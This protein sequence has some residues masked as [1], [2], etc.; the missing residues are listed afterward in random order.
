M[1]ALGGRASLALNSNHIKHLE[2]RGFT[3]NTE[4]G[5]SYYLGE[6]G[7]RNEFEIGRL[8]AVWLM[9]FDWYYF[10]NSETSPY[11]NKSGWHTGVGINVEVSNNLMFRN[12]YIVRFA[13]GMSLL[14]TLGF[15][16]AFGDSSPTSS[17]G[18]S[19][20]KP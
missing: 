15:S 5:K 20:T 16:W 1:A 8:S 13:N 3:S 19:A 7:L 11:L 9:G 2:F 6:I 10:R 12:D 17:G 18:K 4:T 14:V